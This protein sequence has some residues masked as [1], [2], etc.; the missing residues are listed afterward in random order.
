MLRRFGLGLLVLASLA[1]AIP[2]YAAPG[3]KTA[4][5]IWVI[6]P[7]GAASTSA[8]SMRYGDSFSVGWESK[9]NNPYG[10]AQCWTVDAGGTE[11]DP[12]WS[13][14]GYL[15]EDGTIGVFEFASVDPDQYWPADGGTC[16]VSLMSLQGGRQTVRATSPDFTVGP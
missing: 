8:V 15:R 14:W 6:G 4:D 12:F 16:N 10:F 2:A 3:G 1:V 11:A 13:A 9:I 7:V 5:Q